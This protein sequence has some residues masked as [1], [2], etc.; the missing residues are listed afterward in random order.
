M[1]Y[2]C[3][4]QGGEKISRVGKA[5][6]QRVLMSPVDVACGDKDYAM[7]WCE[8]AEVYI[9][10]HGENQRKC[11]FHVSWWD[12]EDEKNAPYEFSHRETAIKRFMQL[13]NEARKRDEAREEETVLG[14][15]D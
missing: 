15:G 8:D 9:S 7:V 14:D 13:R 6:I 4:D 3:Y 1:S 10:R 2:E 11:E 5:S 12:G